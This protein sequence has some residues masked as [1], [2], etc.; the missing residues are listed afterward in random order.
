MKKIKEYLW[1]TFALSLLV[2]FF[3]DD[4][5]CIVSKRGWEILNEKYNHSK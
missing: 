4:S 3:E 1:S 5:H 2:A